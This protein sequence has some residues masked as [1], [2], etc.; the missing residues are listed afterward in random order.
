MEH[1]KILS[2]I[3][4]FSF[5]L[6]QG[7]VSFAQ[8]NNDFC[9]RVK[10]VSC[11]SIEDLSEFSAQAEKIKKDCGEDVLLIFQGKIN[12]CKNAL[13]KEK[14]QTEEELKDIK[15]QEYSAEKT[16][17]NI[18][19]DIKELNTGI[20]S[21]NLSISQLEEVIEE[22]EKLI[23]ELGG[24]LESQKKLLAE[25]LQRIY[26]YDAASSIE[27]LLGHRSLSDF[28][29]KLEETTHLQIDLKLSMDEIKNAQKQ[30]EDQKTELERTKEEKLQN[31]KAQE[32]SRQSL[33]VRKEQQKYFLER[34]A[35]AKTPLEKEMARI[36]TE[37]IEMRN[38]MSRIQQYL[39]QWV[40]QGQV[41]WSS[42]FSAVDN[43]SKISGVRPAL[44]LGILQIESRFGTGLGTP[45]KYKEYCNHKKGTG[46]KYEYQ[47]LEEITASLG[48][49]PNSVP[50]S[51]SCAIGPSQ[52]LPTIWQWY[53]E[54]YGG[55]DNPW[56]LN[57]A[58][59]A[60][61]YYLAR[62]G[63]VSGNEKNAVWNYNHSSSYVNSVMNYAGAW[64]EVIDICGF[65]LNL[66][67]PDMQNKLEGIAN[68]PTQ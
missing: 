63:A 36:E 33:T 64:Q 28:G 52:F 22:K 37:L 40:L 50:M 18:S 20:A 55:L 49:D 60:T 51:K 16:L 17:K 4:I 2:V 10:N 26:E 12:D 68:I 1:I 43:S 24:S 46:K 57:D 15:N 67:C 62:N 35:V 32:I 56:N 29:D 59:L 27:I 44:L 8:D 38:A 58:V 3:L 13:D 65:G 53:Q 54:R 66:S 25:I 14:Q 30:M 41:T 42:I 5:L 6:S 9:S 34:L 39:S 45:G 31:K 61:G 47:A 11:A 23:I 48:Y 21:L 19:F 7:L